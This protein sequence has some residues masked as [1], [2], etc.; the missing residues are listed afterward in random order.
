MERS[1]GKKAAF[2]D[3]DGTLLS[4]ET[5]RMPDSAM[6][7]LQKAHANGVRLFIST[8]RH[9]HEI[10]PERDFGGFPFDGYI[11]CTGQ[12][13][14]CGDEVI[15]RRALPREDLRALCA[16]LER[17]PFSCIFSCEEASY[18]N[19]HTEHLARMEASVGLPLPP[20]LPLGELRDREVYQVTPI[21]GD[22]DLIDLPLTVM[23]GCRASRWNSAFYDIC[24]ADGGKGLS[25]ARMLRRFGI[26]PS[27]AIAFGDGN[28][29]VDMFEAVGTGVAMGNSPESVKLRADY[30]TGSVEQDGIRSA[31]VR[32]GLI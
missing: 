24:P 22:P 3:I 12:Y 26:D 8:G 10:F 20:L 2:F 30:V 27:E 25:V 1:A 23:P 9:P 15:Y 13:C 21:P 7:A 5:H 32:F 16:L 31:F 6:E 17:R 19:L 28:N 4:F 14:Y 11:T 18:T 29:D